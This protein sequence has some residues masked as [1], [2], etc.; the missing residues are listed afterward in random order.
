[1]VWLH[2]TESQLSKTFFQIENQLNIKEIMSTNLYVICI[3]SVNIHSIEY[4]RNPYVLC[5]DF[6]HI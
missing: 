1:M 6:Q 3:Y 5:Q 2:S 4:I